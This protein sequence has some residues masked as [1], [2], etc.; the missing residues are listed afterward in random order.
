[1]E[2]NY[3]FYFS[4]FIFY[5]FSKNTHTHIQTDF[6][7]SI[8]IYLLICAWRFQKKYTEKQDKMKNIGQILGEQLPAKHR[9]NLENRHK[10]VR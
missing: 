7:L 3:T 4:N 9:L 8:Q 1:M 6:Q 2:N 5:S 10:Y